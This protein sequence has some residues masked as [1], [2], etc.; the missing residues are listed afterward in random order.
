MKGNFA[1]GR[2]YTCSPRLNCLPCRARL[3][4]LLAGRCSSPRP[5]APSCSHGSPTF[6]HSLPRTP[7]RSRASGTKP[8]RNQGASSKQ[9]QQWDEGRPPL[10]EC[11]PKPC[12]LT[13]ATGPS[14]LSPTRIHTHPRSPT[15]ARPRSHK[16][17]W[18]VDVYSSVHTL[19]AGIAQASL[20][21]VPFLRRSS[22]W[23]ERRD[24][25]PPPCVGGAVPLGRNASP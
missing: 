6:C 1:G 3:A 10:A 11:A 22:R 7:T 4:C 14:E 16:T 18:E 13:R 23:Y 21:P 19:C 5:L 8:S 15:R 25:E 20:L 17:I 9:Q 12:L 24:M 2:N